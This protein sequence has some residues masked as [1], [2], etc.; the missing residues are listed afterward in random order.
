[1]AF[2]IL[3]PVS[4]IFYKFQFDNK[5]SQADKHFMQCAVLRYL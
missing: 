1:M 5:L 4:H 3:H 2:D